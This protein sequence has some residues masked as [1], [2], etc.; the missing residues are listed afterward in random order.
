MWHES[1]TDDNSNASITPHTKMGYKCI[2]CD[3]VFKYETELVYHKWNSP[4]HF[5]CV[6]CRTTTDFESEDKLHRHYL[7]EHAS[8]YCQFCKENQGFPGLVSWHRSTHNKNKW[9]FCPCGFLAHTVPELEKHWRNSEVHIKTYCTV[10]NLNFPNPEDLRDHN[11]TTCWRKTRENWPQ[12]R[13]RPQA[14]QNMRSQKRPR[15]YETLGIDPSSPQDVV[16]RAAKEKRIACHPD[17]LKRKGG[18]SREESDKID[19]RAVE[20]GYAA[21]I[22]TDPESRRKYDYQ[23]EDGI[24]E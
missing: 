20:V 17:K 15:L 6:F 4:E 23:V 9:N 11:D 22:L 5:M 10:C 24:A 21:D 7:A 12:P 1:R 19:V 2:T 8:E 16:E 3:L 14:R 13:P 18:L